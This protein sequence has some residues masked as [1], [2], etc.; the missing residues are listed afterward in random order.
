VSRIR[1]IF[2][3]APSIP[4]LRLTPCSYN[5]IFCRSHTSATALPSKKSCERRIS[6]DGSTFAATKRTTT[7]S[8]EICFT[9]SRNHFRNSGGW[10]ASTI[11]TLCNNIVTLMMPLLDSSDDALHPNKILTSL[12]STRFSF[13]FTD[14]STRWQIWRFGRLGPYPFLVR[15]PALWRS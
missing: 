5:A 12:I 3:F 14:F 8:N 1:C 15:F 13:L 7:K 6:I 11:G 2:V 9:H 10:K 4:R